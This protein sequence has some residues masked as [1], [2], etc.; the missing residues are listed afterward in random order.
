M[1]GSFNSILTEEESKCIAVYIDEFKKVPPTVAEAKEKALD[2]IDSL[3]I[4]INEIFSYELASD[5]LEFNKKFVNLLDNKA[6]KIMK[7]ES[8]KAEGERSIVPDRWYLGRFDEIKYG[9]RSAV[10]KKK[11]Y[12]ESA[13][14]DS[15]GFANDLGGVYGIFRDDTLSYYATFINELYHSDLKR[16]IEDL[17]G[18]YI[19]MKAGKDMITNNIFVKAFYVI[20]E[21]KSGIFRKMPESLRK[22]YR[23]RFNEFRLDFS[24]TISV[25]DVGKCDSLRKE[26]IDCTACP[27]RQQCSAPVPFSPGYT[28]AVIIGEAPGRDEDES[29]K[30]FIGDAGRLLWKCLKE[31]ND[32][33]FR[34]M[35]HITNIQKCRPKDN[36]INDTKSAFACANRWL[37]KEFELTKPRLILSLG[38]TCL[39]YFKPT[40]KEGIIAMNG[41]V[42]FSEKLGAWI[43]YCIH[44]ASLLYDDSRT[45]AF[46]E[47]LEKFINIFGNLS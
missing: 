39:N 22:K 25:S 4:D 2:K 31:I 12:K 21:L 47:S 24:D 19:L 14:V 27:N 40:S 10:T 46:M 38:R 15:A 26:I 16:T 7:L 32:G 3:N 28:N 34:D 43:V 11:G 44:P 1:A 23:D 20:D 33:L 41:K 29:G 9:Y 5:F 30:P 45:P 13:T 17:A 35:F 42:E 37:T 6:G 8:L 36:K 18:K